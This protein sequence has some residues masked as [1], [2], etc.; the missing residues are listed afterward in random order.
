MQESSSVSCHSLSLF[1]DW[2]RGRGVRE[3]NSVWY[4]EKV[5]QKYYFASAVLFE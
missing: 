2:H 1:S 4:T 5:D 3:E